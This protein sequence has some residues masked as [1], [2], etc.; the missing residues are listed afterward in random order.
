[1]ADD[2]LIEL[3]HNKS[4][5]THGIFYNLSGFYLCTYQANAYYQ[6]LNSVAA[7]LV[8][9]IL[10]ISMLF[11]LFHKKSSRII[12]HCKKLLIVINRLS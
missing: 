1:M 3:P 12:S 6:S 2:S 9:M 8:S 11:L 10:C 7:H 4:N 5:K